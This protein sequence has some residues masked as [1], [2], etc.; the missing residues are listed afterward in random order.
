MKAVLWRLMVPGMLS[1]IR[2]VPENRPLERFTEGIDVEI[3]GVLG[4]SDFIFEDLVSL[5]R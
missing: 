3:Q 4:K 2:N 5:S 1:L